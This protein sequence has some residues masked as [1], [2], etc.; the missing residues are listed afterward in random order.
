MGDI[1]QKSRVTFFV[2]I[3]LHV[4]RIVFFYRSFLVEI[5]N[6]ARTLS[7]SSMGTPGALLSHIFLDCVIFV[8]FLPLLRILLRGASL[9][10]W[11]GDLGILGFL[12]SGVFVVHD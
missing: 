7:S 2:L 10:L 1:L 3:L 12:L 5:E 11:S 4:L 8:C 9:L 6:L